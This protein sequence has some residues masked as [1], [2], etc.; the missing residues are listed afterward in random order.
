GIE[1]GDR[2]NSQSEI[3]DGIETV[4]GEYSTRFRYRCF[5][6]ESDWRSL[7]SSAS[8]E[9]ARTPT[10]VR[11]P[12]ERSEI[13]EVRGAGP[14]YRFAHPGYCTSRNDSLISPPVSPL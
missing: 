9:R 2:G 4:H 7:K 10:S 8:P 5:V 6:N 14:G 12:D 1:T 3:D 13:R 11:S